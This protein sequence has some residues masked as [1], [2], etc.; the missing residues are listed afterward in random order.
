[1]AVPH[2]HNPLSWEPAITVEIECEPMQSFQVSLWRVQTNHIKKQVHDVIEHEK[3]NT[4]R[5]MCDPPKVRTGTKAK[6][7]EHALFRLC[8]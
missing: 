5:V 8:S 2:G 7:I 1:M 4:K 6:S 3:S